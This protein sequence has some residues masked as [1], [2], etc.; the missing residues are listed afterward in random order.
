LYIFTFLPLGEL[1][2]RSA[3][4]LQKNQKKGPVHRLLIEAGEGP[5]KKRIGRSKKR[6]PAAVPSSRG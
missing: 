1:G 5:T 2:G 3:S 6:S 4:L